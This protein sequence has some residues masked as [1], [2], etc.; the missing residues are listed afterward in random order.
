MNELHDLVSDYLLGTLT[1]ADHHAFEQHLDECASCIRQID[2]LAGGL[3]ALFFSQD[4]EPPPGL[5]ESVMAAVEATAPTAG[6]GLEEQPVADVVPIPERRDRTWRMRRFTLAAAAAVV[7]LVVGVGVL[8]QLF[9]DRI[10]QIT[11]ASDAVV[12]AVEPTL[13]PSD[14]NQMSLTY[15]DEERGAVMIATGLDPLGS[16][17]TY[18]MWLIGADGPVSAGLFRP[19]ESGF[20][21]VELAGVPEPGV[22]FGVTIEPAGGS[23]Q[24]TGAVLFLANV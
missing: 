20:V 21:T 16:E 9:Q 6:F 22:A 8:P 14:E 7:L 24:P 23:P 15:S 18:Q 12:L 5:R 4:E 3:E 1:D 17:A 11:G 19:D 2:E 13:G 10:E